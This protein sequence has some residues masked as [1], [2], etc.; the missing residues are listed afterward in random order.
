MK[1]AKIAVLEPNKNKK[2]NKKNNSEMWSIL[3]LLLLEN[4]KEVTNRI[5]KPT[6]KEK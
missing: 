2:N 4:N 1:V 3:L 6:N 5:P